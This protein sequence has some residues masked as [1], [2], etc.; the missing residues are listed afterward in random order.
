[1]TKKIRKIPFPKHIGEHSSQ[2]AVKEIYDLLDMIGQR[3]AVNALPSFDVDAEVVRTVVGVRNLQA[4][5]MLRKVDKVL[6]GDNNE[7]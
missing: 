4:V 7:K 3:V 5:R 6:R 2:E 1:M